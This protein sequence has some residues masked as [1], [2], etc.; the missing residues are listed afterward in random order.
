MNNE[1]EVV[2]RYIS[3]KYGDDV[4]LWSC[5]LPEKYKKRLA[6]SAESIGFVRVE[7]SEIMKV[8]K[9]NL[10]DNLETPTI[11]RNTLANEIDVMLWEDWISMGYWGALIFC[12]SNNSSFLITSTRDEGNINIENL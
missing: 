5:P 2:R 10:K 1:Y 3:N 8:Y 11:D 12:F 6:K 4:R 7:N 9:V